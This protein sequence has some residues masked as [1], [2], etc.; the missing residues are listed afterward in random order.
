[1]LQMVLNKA[2]IADWVVQTCLLFGSEVS[3]AYKVAAAFVEGLEQ[4][5]LKKGQ[6]RPSL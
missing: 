5:R 4:E 2:K 1:M 6:E 3:T